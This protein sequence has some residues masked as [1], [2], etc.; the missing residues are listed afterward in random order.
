MGTPEI[1][2]KR[3]RPCSSRFTPVG[4]PIGRSGDFSRVGASV[5]SA[6]SFSAVEGWRLS[7]TSA[8]GLSATCGLDGFFSGMR[9]P[10]FLCDDKE[11]RRHGQ[12]GV[13]AIERPVGQ[14]QP[15][16][17]YSGNYGVV[18][19]SRRPILCISSGDHSASF[20]LPPAFISVAARL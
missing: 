17:Y 12:V 13:R 10:V 20:S 9:T 1:V 16:F 8:T 14:C 19:A 15:A 5:F 11:R 18:S 4:T 6:H 3:A 7:K 2:V